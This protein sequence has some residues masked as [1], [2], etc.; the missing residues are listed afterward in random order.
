MIRDYPDRPFVGVGIVVF[1]DDEVLLVQRGKAPRMHTWSIPGGAQHVGE[2]V[3]EAAARELMEETGLEA[4]VIGLVDVVDGINREADG[5]VRFHYTLVDFAAEWR[6]GE[7]RPG[8]DVA[9]VRWVPI[10]EIDRFG[11]WAE[12]A[13]I[14]R[15][16]QAMR[17]RPAARRPR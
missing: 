15:R 9:V 5:R 14:I 12:T 2:T 17:R 1:R 11:L 16:A 8:D 10:A 7:A 6:A 4:D 13:R 3:A